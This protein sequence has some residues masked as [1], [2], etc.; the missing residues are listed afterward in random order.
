[1]RIAGILEIGALGIGLAVFGYLAWDG[2]LWDA[3]LQLLL[4]AAALAAAGGLAIL[5]AR[6]EALPRTRIDVPILALLA[7]FALAT[8]SAENHG[9]ALRALAAIIGTAAMLPVA[10]VVLRHRPA[11]TGLV[12]TLPV[13]GLAA[14]TLVTM[15]PRRIE[16][17][18]AGGPGLVPP[19]RLGGDGSPFGSVAVAPFVI[20]GVLPLTLL[21]RDER[22]RRWLQIAL[23]VVGVPLTAF[24][25]S[26]SAWLAIATAAILVSLPLLRR[27]RV[28]GRSDWRPRSIGLA[29]IAAVLAA[30]VLLTVVPRLTAFTSLIYRSFLWRDTLA[31]WSVDPILGIGPGT[32][33]YARQA[34][35]P[36]LTFPVHQPHSH[37]LPLGLLG[38]AGIVGLVAGIA[39]L[40]ALLWVAGPWRQRTLVGRA[41]A[42]V[43]C[44]FAL[45][46]LFEDLTFLPGFNLIVMLL[47]ALA[48]EGAGAVR[49]VR[50]PRGIL[51][52]A[53]LGVAVGTLTLVMLIGDLAGMTYRAGLEAFSAGDYPTAQ[54]LLAR[55]EG[56][57]PWHPM[58]PKA[59]AVAASWNGDSEASR[60]A[61]GRAVALNPGD[62]PSWTNLALVCDVLGDRACSAAAVR[63]SIERA[64]LASLEFINA[65]VLL[66]GERRVEEADAAYR[67][68]LLT[69]RSTGLDFAWPRRVDLEGASVVELGAA[70]QE[71]NQLLAVRIQGGEIDPADF[72]DPVTHALAL[73][74]VGDPSAREAAL[75]AA[76]AD[77]GNVVAWDIAALLTEH[78][79]L[80]ASRELRLAELNRGGASLRGA[81]GLVSVRFDIGSFRMIPA[82][83]FGRSA[84]RLLIDP[85]WPWIL[86][87]L[88]PPR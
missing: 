53:A 85:G 88:L 41:A 8:L 24:S 39:L 5:A 78:A 81:E 64:G 74:F 16:W 32:M 1:M 48:L 87:P 63:Q 50:V 30:G 44:G 14:G 42:A 69:N 76:N 62:G 3:R 61:A 56:L 84:V 75:A 57:D 21:I 36:A 73:A 11:I 23:V 12:V 47:A 80:D 60:Q 20:L 15:L 45:A 4:H 54:R 10:L 66:D 58:T 19:A 49:W 72:D 59:L 70:A 2:A 37:D 27:L 34:A 83:G 17:Y 35:A 38:D 18:V 26:R 7:A 43:L 51:R 71:M 33:P 77:P 46:G 67:Y 40:G 79:G 9:L 82:D 65:A 28:P 86:E 6:R 55:A 25:G 13:L 29:L 52:A 22:I 68:S 31:A